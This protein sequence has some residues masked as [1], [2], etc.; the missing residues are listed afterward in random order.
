MNIWPLLLLFAVAQAIAAD[1]SEVKSGLG[2]KSVDLTSPEKDLNLMWSDSIVP[3]EEML[4][5]KATYKRYG[6][7]FIRQYVFV[8]VQ[9]NSMQVKIQGGNS[10]NGGPAR[11]D[12]SMNETL[13]IERGADRAFHFVPKDLKGEASFTIAPHPKNQGTYSV[14]LVRRK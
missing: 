9:A 12:P 3:G 11:T 4:L 1:W 2:G 14:T 5:S 13:Y 10:S 6:E 7:V 8:G